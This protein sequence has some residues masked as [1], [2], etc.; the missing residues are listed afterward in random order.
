MHDLFQLKL[1][2][3]FYTDF[4]LENLVIALSVSHYLF[5]VNDLDVTKKNDEHDAL[6]IFQTS[7]EALMVDSLTCVGQAKRD[8]DLF[9]KTIY[10]QIL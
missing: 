9:S 6:Y 3:S 10:M 8:I 5:V 2:M 1:L 7:E 4:D